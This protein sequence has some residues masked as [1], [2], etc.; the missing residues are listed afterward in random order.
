MRATDSCIP[1][2]NLS[3]FFPLYLFS[4]Q[5]LILD[6]STE[7]VLALLFGVK[8]NPLWILLFFFLL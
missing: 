6:S 3:L 4:K 2:P 5:I 8:F 7:E 1:S